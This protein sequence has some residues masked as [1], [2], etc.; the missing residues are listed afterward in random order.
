MQIALNFKHR[1]F[2]FVEIAQR[3]LL[4]MKANLIN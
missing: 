4:A 2:G 1:I 3:I